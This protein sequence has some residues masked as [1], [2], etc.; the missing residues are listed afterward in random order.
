M[1]TK[2]SPEPIKY[3]NFALPVSVYKML[4]VKAILSDTTFTNYVVNLL[5]ADSKKPIHL[6]SV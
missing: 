4:K 6:D 5:T 3:A 2:E 1:K